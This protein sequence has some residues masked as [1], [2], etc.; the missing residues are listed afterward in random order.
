MN[1]RPLAAKALNRECA[2]FCRYLIGEEPNEYVRRKYL[3][4]HGSRS[5]AGV[6]QPNP[7]ER[8]LVE[9]ARIGP[10]STRLIDAYTRIFRPFSLVRKKLV[11]LLAI[12]ES[13]A[14][15]HLY[16]DSIDSTSVP[17]LLLR[18]FRRCVTFAFLL[19]VASLVL[20]PLE[21]AVRASSKLVMSR[22]PRHG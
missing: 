5:F 11:L 7:P 9:V 18:S 19:V 10:W 2:I 15:T 13:C 22:L 3:E 6:E 16:L 8:F 17:L 21:L 12:L 4:A 14:P 20:F 1:D